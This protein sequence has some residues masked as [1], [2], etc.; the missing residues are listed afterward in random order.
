M[1]GR[2]SD[3]CNL[4]YVQPYATYVFIIAFPKLHPLLF[5]ASFYL[6]TVMNHTFE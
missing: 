2:T 4:N 6:L 3:R 1:F 5:T